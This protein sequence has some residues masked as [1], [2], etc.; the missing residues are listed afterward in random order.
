M[1]TQSCVIYGCMFAGKTT[2]LINMYSK[3]IEA[4]KSIL[5]IKH[6]IDTRYST[7]N[8]TSHTGMSI[9]ATPYTKLSDV[10]T[11]MYA[12]VE[13][14]II[15]EAQFF[16]DLI[17]FLTTLNSADIKYI[18]AGL[19]LDCMKSPFGQTLQATYMTSSNLRLRA[20]CECGNDAIYTKKR[21]KVS[22]VIEVGGSELYAPVCDTCY[23]IN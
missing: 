21:G 3:L 18:V 6:A 2:T 4:G 23:E 1:A 10:A 13:W 12:N 8:I 17:E 5:V 14:V 16:P 9:A 7:N 11:T 19:D 22:H 15:D 20:K